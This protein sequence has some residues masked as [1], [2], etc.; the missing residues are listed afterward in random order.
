MAAVQL[1]EVKVLNNP[2]SFTSE[3]QFFIKFHCLDKLEKDL[4][5][6]VTYVGSATS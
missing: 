2:T 4:E 1:L 3:Y 5:F 6:N